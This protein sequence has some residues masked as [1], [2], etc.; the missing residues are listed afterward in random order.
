MASTRHR[1]S[2]HACAAA[3]PEPSRDR[4]MAQRGHRH[5]PLPKTLAV[6]GRDI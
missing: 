4:A 5:D 6:R 2:A 1:L 3:S